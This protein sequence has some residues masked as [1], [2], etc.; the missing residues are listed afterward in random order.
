MTEAANRIQEQLK[1]FSPAARIEEGAPRGYMVGD[2]NGNWY[3]APS[4]EAALAQKT[5]ECEELKEKH[6]YFISLY[7]PQHKQALEERDAARA[8]VEQLERQVAELS[9]A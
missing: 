8:Q 4:V 3:F 9:K 1:R 6:A 2:K 5:R 7:E